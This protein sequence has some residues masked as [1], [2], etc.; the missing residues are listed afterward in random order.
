[1]KTWWT[2]ALACLAMLG[3]T[4][5]L[6][7]E[8]ILEKSD[9]EGHVLTRQWQAFHK[10]ANADRP[11]EMTRL[12]EDILDKAKRKH[13][14]KDFY[15]AGREW[16]Y[17]VQRR[18]WKERDDALAKWAKEVAAFDEPVVTL[19]WMDEFQRAGSNTRYE[20]ARDNANRLKAA[21]HAEFYDDLS[22]MDGNLSRFSFFHN[23]DSVC[24]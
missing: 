24:V 16:V 8:M 3:A 21:R 22:W 14:S 15:D 9:A 11:Q 18:N 7:S 6:K 2:G 23:S 12:L 4:T 20:Y 10:A 13:L 17:A 5:M 1:M 19:A